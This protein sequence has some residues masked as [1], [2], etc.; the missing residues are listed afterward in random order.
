MRSLLDCNQR[1]VE[2]LKGIC[3]AVN[4]LLSLAARLCPCWAETTT[5]IRRMAPRHCQFFT[6]CHPTCAISSLSWVPS[7]PYQAPR[8]RVST[9]DPIAPFKSDIIVMH[10]DE[11]VT[12]GRGSSGRSSHPSTGRASGSSGPCDCLWT[13]TS[14]SML[15]LLLRRSK[16]VRSSKPSRSSDQGPCV[17]F[18]HLAQL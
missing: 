4:P 12:R 9:D 18:A 5:V 14:T 2:S 1:S 16:L 13:T 3:Q 6:A 8:C 7:L 17:P 11:Y 15:L 10:T